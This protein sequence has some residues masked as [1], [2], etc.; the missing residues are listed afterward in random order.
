VKGH[1]L[2]NFIGKVGKDSAA[3]RFASATASDFSIQ[4]DKPYAEV[5]QQPYNTPGC[6]MNNIKD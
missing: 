5:G 2:N 3:A 4:Q 6:I 1:D